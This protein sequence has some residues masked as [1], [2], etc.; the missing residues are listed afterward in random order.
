VR[1]PRFIGGEFGGRGAAPPDGSPRR[2][3][4]GTRR[5]SLSPPTA[6]TSSSRTTS[7]KS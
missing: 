4:A 7:S 3:R 5:A 1:P 6:S 2:P